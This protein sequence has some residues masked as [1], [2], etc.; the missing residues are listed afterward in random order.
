M[1]KHYQVLITYEN[2][3]VLSLIVLI[4]ITCTVLKHNCGKNKYLEKYMHEIL[5][6][7]KSTITQIS[8]TKFTAINTHMYVKWATSSNKLDTGICN[9]D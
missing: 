7:V 3:Q 9:S 5:T 1:R 8:R 4:H 6:H 2:L